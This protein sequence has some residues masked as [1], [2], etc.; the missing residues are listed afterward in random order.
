MVVIVVVVVVVV[1]VFVLTTWK[2]FIIG[3]SLCI[4]ATNAATRRRDAVGLVPC[5][6]ILLCS[7]LKRAPPCHHVKE[8]QRDAPN[9]NPEQ[10]EMNERSRQKTSKSVYKK[11]HSGAIY[12]KYLSNPV[13]IWRDR[14]I[15]EMTSFECGLHCIKI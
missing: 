1:V 12:N 3:E 4:F 14:A 5:D 6:V 11:A 7:Y 13:T 10:S 2:Q 8:R 9:Q 15:L